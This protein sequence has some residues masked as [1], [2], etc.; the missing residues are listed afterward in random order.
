MLSAKND[1]SSTTAAHAGL[2]LWSFSVEK[3]N[4]ACDALDVAMIFGSLH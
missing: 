3:D 2:C 1:A 4:F